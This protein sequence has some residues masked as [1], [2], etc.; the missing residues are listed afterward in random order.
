[1]PPKK[2][3]RSSAVWNAFA[4]N[5]GCS[6]YRH[7]DTQVISS[8]NSAMPS[9]YGERSTWPNAAHTPPPSASSARGAFAGAAASRAAACARC[10]RMTCLMKTSD[11]ASSAAEIGNRLIAPSGTASRLSMNG[12]ISPP[13]LAPAQ[14]APNRRPACSRVN[15]SAIRLQN[16]ATTNRLKTLTHTK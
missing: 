16:A 2:R 7:V 1:M 6:R 13:V 8:T 12:P 4:P 14:M 3:A 11:S 10:Q 15:T 5:A 9:R